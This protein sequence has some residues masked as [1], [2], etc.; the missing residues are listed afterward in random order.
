MQLQ[1]NGMSDFRKKLGHFSHGAKDHYMTRCA[2]TMAA[3]GESIGL[4]KFAGTFIEK[5]VM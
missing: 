2:S 3:L 5:L 4:S 1:L